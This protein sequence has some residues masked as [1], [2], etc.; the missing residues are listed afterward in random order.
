ME[1]STLCYIYFDILVAMIGTEYPLTIDDFYFNKLR[2]NADY[3]HVY[4]GS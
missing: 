1:I 3:M 2:L 4:L